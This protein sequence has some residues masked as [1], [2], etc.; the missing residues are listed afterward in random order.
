[1]L[2]QKYVTFYA[3][4]SGVPLDVAERD[5]VL[6]YVLRILS[7]SALPELAFKGGTCLKKTYFGRTG[8]FSMDLDFTSLGVTVEKLKNVLGDQLHNRTHYGIDFKI[9]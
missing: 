5:M 3:Q 1:M 8:R 7:E 9:A 2:D 4:S 6:T